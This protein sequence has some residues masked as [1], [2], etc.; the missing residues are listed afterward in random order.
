MD[1]VLVEERPDGSFEVEVKGR[2]GSTRYRVEAVA[3]AASAIGCEDVA[4]ADLVRASFSFLLEREP[5]SSILSR[6]RLL[7]IARYFPDYPSDIARRCHGE[8]GRG[9]RR[10]PNDL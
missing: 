4:A 8:D 9:L 7:D 2:R 3:E 10:Q 6:F 1:T 5:A